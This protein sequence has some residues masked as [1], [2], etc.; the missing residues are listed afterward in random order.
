MTGLCWTS[1]AASVNQLTSLMQ[2][3]QSGQTHPWTEGQML[4]SMR[5]GHE[6]Q[7][8]YAETDDR[9]LVGFWIGMQGVDEVHLLNIAVHPHWRGQGVGRWMLQQLAVWATTQRA[10]LIWLEVRVSNQRAIDLYR[11][12]GFE[13]IA[14]RPRYYPL[15]MNEREDA[16][17]FRTYP[18][19]LLQPK[20][21]A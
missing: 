17:I 16:L 15:T 9:P 20:G 13:Q 1:E 4:D 2:L 12:A 18:H 14:V 6:V 3:E 11:K 10:Q 21:Q 7:V 5:C 8:V 19:A